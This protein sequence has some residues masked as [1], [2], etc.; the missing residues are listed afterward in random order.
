[1]ATKTS[2]LPKEM[3]N[4]MTDIHFFVRLPCMSVTNNVHITMFV[5]LGKNLFK[6]LKNAT[7]KYYIY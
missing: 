1:M 5:L 7:I 4:S 6:M 2:S 3:R